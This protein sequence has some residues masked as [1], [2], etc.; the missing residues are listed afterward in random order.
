VKLGSLMT[1]AL[2]LWACGGTQDARSR[3]GGGSTGDD[4]PDAEFDCKAQR[5]EDSGAHHTKVLEAYDLWAK[6]MLGLTRQ[7]SATPWAKIPP[8][9]RSG[10]TARLRA[11]NDAQRAEIAT[12]RGVPADEIKLGCTPEF[13]HCMDLSHP[14]NQ[15]DVARWY[16]Q[17]VVEALTDF[18]RLV[19]D[20][21]STELRVVDVIMASTGDRADARPVAQLDKLLS[22]ARASEEELGQAHA[23]V[24]QLLTKG[25]TVPDAQ[26]PAPLRPRDCSTEDP[27]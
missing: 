14:S 6:N 11:H 20:T 13:P 1:C 24:L 22:E 10:V 23:K 16:G 26:V 9:G 12:R 17:V 3:P 25:A 18:D 27:R 19:S 5:A 7:F 21:E 2:C 15:R 4:P 8:S